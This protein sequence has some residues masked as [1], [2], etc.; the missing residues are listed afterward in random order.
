MEVLNDSNTESNGQLLVLLHLSQLLNLITGFGGL[1][2]PLIIW[3]TQKDRV[4][5]MDQHG[6]EVMNFQITMII[7]A[8]IAVPCIL[9]F[10]L[11][12]LMLIG[13]GILTLILPIVGGIKA[14]NGEYF[15]YPF[16]IEFIK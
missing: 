8:V 5:D 7:A 11:G 9:L 2:V 16:S 6:K 13:I 4:T 3:L 10:G 12:I 1:I 14:S 15:K